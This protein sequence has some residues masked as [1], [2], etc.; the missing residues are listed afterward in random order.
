MP[1]AKKPTIS[2]L[3]IKLFNVH[4]SLYLRPTN[5]SST[6]TNRVKMKK[7]NLQ[8]LIISANN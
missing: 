7:T 8:T 6:G 4:S 3:G 5:P 2:H 1:K